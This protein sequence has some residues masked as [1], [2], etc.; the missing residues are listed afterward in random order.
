M[1]TQ[2]SSYTQPVP[3]ASVVSTLTTERLICGYKSVH[4][5]TGVAVGG[6]LM[7]VTV[8]GKAIGVAVGGGVIGVGVGW[9]VAVGGGVIGVGVG[10]GV[11]AGWGVTVG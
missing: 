2:P 11:G 3:V 9:G 10:W 7:G 1:S 8:G 5:G 4:V 6:R